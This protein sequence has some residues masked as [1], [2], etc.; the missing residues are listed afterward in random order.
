MSARSAAIDIE[1]VAGDVGGFVAGE[2]TM[3]AA[4]SRAVPMRPSGM[5]VVQF[6]FHFVG[7]HVG[8]GR[9]DEARRDGVH[10]DVARGDF[11]GDRR[12]RPIRPALAAT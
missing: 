3:A 12:V 6:V 5:R 4:T 10:G 9:D 7:E 2:K 1:D 11:D 8:H